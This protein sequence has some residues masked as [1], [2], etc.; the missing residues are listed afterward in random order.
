ML[1]G[2]SVVIRGK[3]NLLHVDQALKQYFGYDSFRSGQAEVVDAVLAQRDL[4]VLMPT[5]GGKSLTY[6]LPA[7]LMPGLTIV[8]SPLIALM[9]DQVSRL[10]ANGIEATFINSSLPYTEVT[11]R[12][13][14]AMRGELKLLYVAPER[15]VK[16]SFLAFLDHIEHTVGL[17]LLAVD[18][19][20]CVSEWGHDFRPEYRQLGA[21][22]QRFPHV[23]VLALTA[24]ATERV[25]RDILQQLNLHDPI[26]H[27]ASF[28]RANLSY[29]VR[30]KDK[31]SYRELVALLRDL[32]GESVIIYCLSRSGVEK[33]SA[34][35]SS[36]GIL[37]LPYH[38]GLSNTVRSEH[39]E[40]FIRDDVPVL[41]ATVAFGMGIAKPDVRAVIHY[42]LPKN[43]EGYYQESGRAGRDGQPA[44][45]VLF[46]S[47]GDRMRVEYVIGQKSD[48]Q[49]QAIALRQLQQVITYCDSGQ[50][51]RHLLLGYFGEDLS[52]IDCHNCDNC[53]NA[54]VEEDRTAEAQKFLS[55][56]RQTR[57]RFGLRQIVDVLRGANTQKVR[58][59]RH[60]LLPIYGKGSAL[61]VD[62]WT[63]IGRSLLRQG[64][65]GERKE[66][67][68]TLYL[69]AR[70]QQILSGDVAFYVQQMVRP[71]VTASVSS[72]SISPVAVIE[73]DPLATALFQQL[74]TLRKRLADEMGVPPYVIFPDA[75]L[76]A[77]VHSL[78]V[79]QS[80]FLRLPGVGQQKLNA[81]SAPFI[82]EMQSYLQQYP[83]FGAALHSPVTEKKSSAPVGVV[84]RNAIELAK[85]GFDANEI[86]RACS[87]QP[88]TIV[89]YLIEG[90]ESGEVF[91]LT[92]F[93]SADHYTP[94]YDALQRSED[95]KL[96][97]IKDQLGEGYSYN[98]IRFVRAQISAEAR[99]AL[100]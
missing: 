62:E 43:L 41:V 24:T 95:G 1:D 64:C 89:D 46:F 60:N 28:N 92:P 77:M 27:I 53:L 93:V 75:T 47:Y 86:A 7:L 90:L 11:R 50:C 14:A 55:C 48:E 73:N 9:Q 96:R 76:W 70:S 20:H 78:P 13:Q 22:R 68:S 33:L 16:P 67:Y 42:D 6:Q 66:N 35:L 97:P 10:Q 69:N 85:Q 26:V 94:I 21:V 84:R 71:K 38:A 29:E 25:R 31:G 51:R 2:Y 32:P 100:R 61:S 49:Q 34:E 39:Q 98:E 36:D 83:E 4:L 8:V 30:K 56:V 52:S 99:K 54:T 37:N 63:S 57:E 82:A 3:L 88:S 12:E 58:D 15:L 65:L 5:G 17:S 72:T 59:S 79:N 40:R 91:E 80:E 44:K 19:A 18:E 87:R 81:Y 45:C 74:R 23:P